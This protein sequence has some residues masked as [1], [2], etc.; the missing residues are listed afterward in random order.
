[1]MI[2]R[3]LARIAC[4]K[5][6]KKNMKSASLRT[7]KVKFFTCSVFIFK[8]H[9]L[10]RLGNS[11]CSRHDVNVRINSPSCTFSYRNLVDR[12]I[13]F[14]LS[15]KYKANFDVSSEDIAPGSN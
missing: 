4:N 10:C 1:M 13:L 9:S 12:L 11:Y 3:N 7:F 15:E 6:G 2:L 14:K 8:K 5:E